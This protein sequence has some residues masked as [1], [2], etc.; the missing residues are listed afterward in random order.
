MKTLI[1][2]VAAKYSSFCRTVHV[3]SQTTISKH[4][5][6]IMLVAGIGLVAAG[7]TGLALAQTGDFDDSKIVDVADIILGTL[8]EGSFGALI[9]IIAGL[10]AIISAAMGAYRAAM[11]ALVVAVGA[12]ILRSFV[13]IF[14]SNVLPSS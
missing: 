9:M 10:I 5:L 2:K 8:V 6:S 12:F 3:V 7:G 14:F 4:A 11:A 1:E 13:N